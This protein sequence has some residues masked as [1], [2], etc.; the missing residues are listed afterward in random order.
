MEHILMAKYLIF[1]KKDKEIN[2][3]V[4]ARSKLGTV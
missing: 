3:A 1:Q 2:Y 4:G